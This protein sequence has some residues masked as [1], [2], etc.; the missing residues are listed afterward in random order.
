MDGMVGGWMRRGLVSFIRTYLVGLVA[1]LGEDLGVD[2]EDVGHGQEGNDAGPDLPADGRASFFDLEVVEDALL[3]G[4]GGRRRRG[5]VPIVV[6]GVVVVA[7]HGLLCGGGGGG[8][9][10]WGWG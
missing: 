8:W 6:A 1:D 7:V 3:E 4:V 9:G 10:G 2:E 5:V